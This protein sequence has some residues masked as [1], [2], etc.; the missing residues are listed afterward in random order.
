MYLKNAIRDSIKLRKKNSL[1]K[2]N[3]N[4]FIDLIFKTL[5]KKKKV[6]ICGNGGS[7][8]EAQHLAAEFLVRLN[9]NVNRRPFP[10]ISLAQDVSTITACSNDYKFEEL[11]SRNLEGMANIGDLLICLSTSGNSKNIIKVLKKAKKI[12]ITSLSLLGN[13]GGKSKKF[14]D[15]SIIVKSKNTA[16]IQEEHLFLGH[17]I[18]NEVEK[19]L[20]RLM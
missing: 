18:L 11:F 13:N 9:P 5:T 12:G 7:A 14:T 2:R 16:L 8:A 4:T 20:L 3:I 10:I 15:H 17:L 1:N 6:F 19:K